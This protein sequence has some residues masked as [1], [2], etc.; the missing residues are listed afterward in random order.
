MTICASND[1]AWRAHSRSFSVVTD[2]IDVFLFVLLR[3]VVLVIASDII[4]RTRL[5]LVAFWKKDK[6]GL[7]VSRRGSHPSY[8]NQIG[9]RRAQLRQGWT[10]RVWSSQ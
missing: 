1:A 10:H 9:E 8:A 7:D 5:Y 4:C 3:V 2:C 6:E